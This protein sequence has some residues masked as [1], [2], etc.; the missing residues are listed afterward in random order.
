MKRCVIL[1]AALPIALLAQGCATS[2]DEADA[3]A[4]AVLDVRN[5]PEGASGT[6]TCHFLVGDDRFTFTGPGEVECLGPATGAT[7]E[8]EGFQAV[9]VDLPDLPRDECGMPRVEIPVFDVDP[10]PLEVEL[11]R[12]L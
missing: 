3:V 7:V 5:V 2:C 11:S 9:T 10:V 6:L 8:V 4:F 12:S 1:I